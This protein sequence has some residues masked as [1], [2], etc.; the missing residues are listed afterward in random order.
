MRRDHRQQQVRRRAHVEAHALVGQ[1]LHQLGILDGPHAVLDAVGARARRARRRTLA[2]PGQLA[3][4]GR[5][6][7][8][9]V[10]GDGEG[11]GERLGR[12]RRLVVGQPERRPRRGR[13]S[14]TASVGLGDGVGRVEVR[15][16]ATISPV[17]TP[18]PLGGGRQG[19]EQ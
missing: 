14:A 17:P 9:G 6:Q 3:G 7:Q 2:G 12:P 8:A 10:A 19:V 18:V 5:A 15:S 11:L 13:R 16:A 1:A 4:V